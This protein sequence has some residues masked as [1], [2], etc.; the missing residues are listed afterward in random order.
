MKQEKSLKQRALE[1]LA[2]REYTRAE[3]RAK[4]APHSES[5]EEIEAVLGEME[6]RGWLS[7]GRFAEQLVATRRGRFGS[8]RIAHELRQRGVPDEVV[9]SLLPGLEED[10]LRVAREIWRQKFGKRPGT[11][12]ERAKQARFLQGRGFSAELIRR[13]LRFDED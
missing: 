13:A 8:L 3:L 6:A 12:A 1:C 2:R 9:D 4:L 11:P 7:E 10:D 5:A